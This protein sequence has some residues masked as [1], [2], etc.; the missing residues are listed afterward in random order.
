[1]DAS[2]ESGIWH[3][4]VGKSK[5]CSKNRR[6]TTY[7]ASS[8]TRVAISLRSEKNLM[9]MYVC[10]AIITTGRFRWIIRLFS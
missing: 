5:E 9:L 10:S 3:I 2:N 7:N 1:M 8:T 4:S 6:N